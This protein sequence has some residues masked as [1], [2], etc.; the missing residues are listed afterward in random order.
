MYNLWMPR[1]YTKWM[2]DFQDQQNEAGVVSMVT[3]RACIEEDLVWSA[4]FILIPWWQYVQYGDRR[5]LEENY[6]AMKRYLEYLEATGTR[7]IADPPCGR[8]AKSLLP[9]VP[10]EAR[11]PTDSEKGYLQKS[12]WGDHLSTTGS[13]MRSGTPLSIGAAFYY[14]D[15]VVMSEIART[16]GRRDDAASFASL[17][18]KIKEA[19]N[20][21]FFHPQGQFYD[22][23]IQ[24]TQIWPLAFGL[25][26]EE[27]QS[28]V[29]DSLCG[30]IGSA[31]GHLTTGYI[32][33]KFALEVLAANGR[34]DL[35]WQ[36]ANRSDYPSWGYMLRKG[37]STV[38]EYWDGESGSWNHVALGA[39]LD[40]WLY[41]ALAGIRADPGQP[42]FEHVIIEP[43]Y[44]D[45]LQWVRA[46]VE[47][48]RGTVGSS[49]RRDGDSVRLDVRI[50]ANCHATIGIPANVEQIRESGIPVSGSKEV[51]L[52]GK[53]E[54]A[55]VF[56]TG[57]GSYVFHFI[58]SGKHKVGSFESAL[59][60][61]A[62]AIG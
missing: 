37:R 55:S 12:Q 51:R 35:V 16:I 50:P 19:F 1:F 15:A 29:F 49:W 34:N 43:Y 46:S 24:S 32:A 30:L 28:S 57:S 36:L 58:P 42:G 2:R 54:E 41:S 5:I 20:R 11:F 18:E 7:E 23:G 59:S 60:E 25:V 40:Q 9:S 26:A 38:T 48:M 17:S 56:A 21:R 33:T 31:S 39:A 44:P 4:A 10:V 52:I 62:I 47:T 3:P 14:Q 8:P 22:G 27:D 53:K 13:G 61:A 45:D 6:P